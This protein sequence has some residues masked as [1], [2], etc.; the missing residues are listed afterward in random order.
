MF[1]C[2]IIFLSQDINQNRSIQDA[3]AYEAQFFRDHPVFYISF[4]SFNFIISHTF[5]CDPIKYL[6]V[7]NALTDRC[8]IPQLAKKLNQVGLIVSICFWSY[9]LYLLEQHQN[10]LVSLLL[11]SLVIG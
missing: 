11:L 6:Q 7:Y 9:Y 10:F 5:L 8:G 2:I 3:L 4:D 1:T